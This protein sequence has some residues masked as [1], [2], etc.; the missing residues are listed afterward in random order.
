MKEAILKELSAAI[1]IFW[2][3]SELL[4]PCN[5]NYHYPRYFYWFTKAPLSLDVIGIMF[6]SDNEGFSVC[7]IICRPN[8]F[9]EA[10]KE[11]YQ[12]TG[13][14]LGIYNHRKFQVYLSPYSKD[15]YLLSAIYD[16]R[17]LDADTKVDT[18]ELMR[19]IKIGFK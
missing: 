6:N 18:L 4:V 14:D 11:S 13:E 7:S 10:F 17:L 1:K 9:L 2:P 15:S 12:Q 5:G 8:G 19:W 16:G 3:D